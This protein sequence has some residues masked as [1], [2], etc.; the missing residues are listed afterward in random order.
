MRTCIICGT[1]VAMSTT[2]SSKLLFHTFLP[3]PFHT[4]LAT[5]R[6]WLSPVGQSLCRSP[7]I[8]PT[9]APW[10][11]AVASTTTPLR[12]S[13]QHHRRSPS[14]RRVHPLHSRHVLAGSI[15]SDLSNTANSL[16]IPLRRALQPEQ[17]PATEPFRRLRPSEIVL[18]VLTTRGKSTL[19]GVHVREVRLPRDIR[20][21]E[22]QEA[23]YFTA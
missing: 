20:R 4:R 6:F 14:P 3:R 16:I 7:L 13:L 2:S 15:G 1:C 18:T 11:L 12:G 5:H 23:S 21:H 22:D 17:P 10:S 9:P 8:R 19:G